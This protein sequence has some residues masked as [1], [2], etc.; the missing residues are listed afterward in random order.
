MAAIRSRFVDKLAH[1]TALL[2]EQ[3]GSNSLPD[4]FAARLRNEMHEICG[5][6]STLGLSEVGD[7][8]RSLE[9]I[10]RGALE[11]DRPLS[12]A[13]LSEIREGLSTLQALAASGGSR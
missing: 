3:I 1:R 9:T 4:E 5:T 7:R 8:A 12:D 6:G 10:A 11:Q 2:S 13:E